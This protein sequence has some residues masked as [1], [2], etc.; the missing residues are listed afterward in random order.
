MRVSDL[1]PPSLGGIRL[2]KTR[3]LGLDVRASRPFFLARNGPS[4]SF[5]PRYIAVA[6][7]GPHGAARGSAQY[8]GLV[9]EQKASCLVLA[10]AAIFGMAS[11]PDAGGVGRF[12]G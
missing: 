4:E 8:A 9:C 10:G 12:F 6:D 11:S 5:G 2:E 1:R 3:E 7:R